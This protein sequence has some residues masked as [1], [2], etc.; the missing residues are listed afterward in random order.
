[1]K[2]GGSQTTF[3]RAACLA[4]VDED[5]EE[6]KVIDMLWAFFRHSHHL[7]YLYHKLCNLLTGI[8]ISGH[9]L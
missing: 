6:L 3:C 7:M 8:M 2:D 9:N 4:A 5:S 1:M